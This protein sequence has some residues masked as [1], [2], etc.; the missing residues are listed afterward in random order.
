MCTYVSVYV[1]YPFST[2]RGQKRA[3]YPLE[4]EFQV[5]MSHPIWVLGTKSVLCKSSKPISFI[6]T[7]TN[8]NKPPTF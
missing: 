7:K 5:A 4:L 3:S 2:H 8:N 6:K 1:P